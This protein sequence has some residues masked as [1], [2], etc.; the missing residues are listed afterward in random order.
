[1]KRKKSISSRKA[2]KKVKEEE[3]EEVKEDEK[4]AVKEQEHEKKDND[5]SKGTK[6]EVPWQFNQVLA[7]GSGDMSQLGFGHTVQERKFPG[8]VKSLLCRNVA[9]IATG[10]LHNVVTLDNG[11]VWTWG[12]NDDNALGRLDDEWYP[13]PVTALS[14]HKVVQVACGDCHSIALTDSGDVYSWGTYKDIHGYIGYNQSTEKQ[15]LPAIIPQLSGRSIVRISA[16]EHHDL[17]LTKFGDVYEWGDTRLGQRCSE[18][19]KKTKLT[20][21]SLFI[22][23][24]G[25]KLKI[26]NVFAIGMTNFAIAESGAVYSWGLNN[27]GQTGLGN[28]SAVL[29]PTLVAALRELK[30]RYIAGAAH[31]VLALS[32]DHK[33]YSWGRGMYGRLGHG[34]DKDLFIPT[35]IQ[36]LSPGRLNRCSSS[37]L[38]SASSSSSSDGKDYVVHIGAGDG[39]S[40]AV[41]A[42][43]LLYTWGVGN[44]LQLGTGEEDDEHV[45]KLV[46][47]K[48]LTSDCGRQVLEASGGA[49]HTLILARYRKAPS[50]P[51]YVIQNTGEEGEKMIVI[52]TSSSLSCSSSSSSSS[53]STASSSLDSKS[54]S[55]SS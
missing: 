14:K 41:T 32:E 50:T 38:S 26:V 28:T 42:A 51:M 9:H 52:G 19:S 25:K 54:T 43:G 44:C 49:Q 47:G 13:S 33:V 27:Y 21:R 45:P 31:H 4:I 36:A 55:T 37:S 18:R 23:E 29:V 3:K 1:M 46:Q 24:K 7:F 53:S 20:P 10:G 17:A 39:H 15:A 48:E 35:E 5:K 30:I 8:L 34:D 2:T 11:E 6:Q 12:C 40:M 16:G 22:R